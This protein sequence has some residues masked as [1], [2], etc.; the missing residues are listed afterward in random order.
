M[1][2]MHPAGDTGTSHH[3]RSQFLRVMDLKAKG[4]RAIMK[5][6][7]LTR[8]EQISNLQSGLFVAEIYTVQVLAE[9][10]LILTEVLVVLFI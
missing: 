8:T 4:Y 9:S 5:S 1:P 7:I 2:L 6:L 10:P 3:E